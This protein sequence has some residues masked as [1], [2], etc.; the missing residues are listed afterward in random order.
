MSV[1]SNNFE[2]N[3]TSEGLDK[4]LEDKNRGFSDD[5]IYWR[6]EYTFVEGGQQETI[7]FPENV[8]LEIDQSAAEKRISNILEENGNNDKHPIEIRNILE[9][10][11]EDVYPDD[12]L[13]GNQMPS[14]ESVSING[15]HLN[16]ANIVTDRSGFTYS[17]YSESFRGGANVDLSSLV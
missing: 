16:L 14:P 17:S 6:G 7:Y 11:S 2:A 4:R 10:A 12:T 1:E 9:G 3:Q 8:W 15:Y 13:N 5:S